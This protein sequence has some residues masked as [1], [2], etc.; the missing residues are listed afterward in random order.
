MIESRCGIVCSECGFQESHGCKGC[1]NID[2]PFWGECPVKTSCESKKHAHCGEC[3]EFPCKLLESFAYADNEHG[4]DGKRIEQCRK[5]AG[6]NE[7]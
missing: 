4:D 3:G 2:N 5:W 6:S 1:V 7:T